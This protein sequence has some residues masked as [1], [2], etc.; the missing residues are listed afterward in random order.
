MPIDTQMII[1]FGICTVFPIA[2][3][4]VTLRHFCWSRE[5]KLIYAVSN[6]ISLIFLLVYIAFLYRKS[7]SIVC[8][9][10]DVANNTTYSPI[11]SCLSIIGLICFIIFA[12]FFHHILLFISNIFDKLK[13]LLGKFIHFL[14][15]K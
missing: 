1:V 3:L 7:S 15:K 2:T 10:I 11:N 12:L 4:L 9:I 5:A 8:G 14:R 6:F 13:K